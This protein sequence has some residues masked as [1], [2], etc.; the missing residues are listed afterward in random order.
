MLL[1]TISAYSQTEKLIG[2]WENCKWICNGMTAMKHVCSEIEFKKNQTVVISN[3]GVIGESYKWKIKNNQIRFI[4]LSRKKN[5]TFS[6]S[7]VYKLIFNKSS[8]ELVIREKE[9][10]KCYDV[11]SRYSNYR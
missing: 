6:E 4:N 7:K 8:N 5:A 3:S 10:G 11:L 2:K 9:N 1:F